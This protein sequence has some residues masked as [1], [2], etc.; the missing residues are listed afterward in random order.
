MK[1]QLFQHIARA[2]C[3]MENC[4][5][6]GNTEWLSR[7]ESNIETLVSDFLPSGSGVD[8]GTK[9]DWE[10][11]SCERQSAGEYPSR[12][13]FNVAFH[14]INESG[15]YDGWTEHKVI[16]RPSLCFGFDLKITG[17]DRN[18]IKEYLG[19]LYHS[20]LSE[21]IEQTAEGYKRA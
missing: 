14:H 6:S 21:E 4:R 9:L 8:C 16:V 18:G 20:A 3:A 12:F 5:R 19:D 15:M 1:A 13:V 2:L 11:S 7:H 17:R 10:A